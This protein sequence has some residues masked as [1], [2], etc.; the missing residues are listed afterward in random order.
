MISKRNSLLTDLL[1]IGLAAGLFIF[2]S[3]SCM[4]EQEE[5]PKSSGPV[6]TA[7]KTV[8]T[9]SQKEPLTYNLQ[10]IHPGDPN[11]EPIDLKL[12][13]NFDAE[14]NP[15]HY[16]LWVDSV[17]CRDKTCE[18]VK[19]EMFWDAFG[20]YDKYF[21]E[22]GEKLTKLDHVPFSTEDHKKLQRIL[23]D[24]ESP[25]R[26][27]T[28]DGLVGEKAKSA[29]DGVA[30]ATVL[31]L[32]STVVVGAGY[33]C[34]DLWHWANG[35]VSQIIRQKSGESFSVA[36][37]KKLLQSEKVDTVQFA[38]S[39]LKERK[40]FDQSTVNAVVASM[41]TGG[42]ELIEAALPYLKAASKT[43]ADYFKSVYD[44][45]ADCSSDK[46]V[47]ILTALTADSTLPSSEYYDLLS[48]KISDLKS[49]HEVHLLLTL[50]E[51]RK[52]WSLE[53]EKN[54]ISLLDHPK[55]FFS[56]RAYWFLKKNKVSSENK[57]KVDAYFK[58]H[59][60]RLL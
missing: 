43:P 31:T 38:I 41:K 11:S 22:F 24:K 5:A 48:S 4:V 21:V 39:Y 55:F 13:Q 53:I 52:A 56:R 25:L 3:L 37:L 51:K 30:G 44:I 1:Q 8:T 12:V 29:V 36:K 23:K 47:F 40:V 27:V 17:I 46:R 16:S 28:K 2:L 10:I 35:E 15:K 49:Y 42:D 45:Y 34:Y 50:F 14:G 59:Q 9:T 54:V 58:K 57:P 32:N 19:V 18:V 60:L 7:D 26:E 6:S 33:T 20:Q